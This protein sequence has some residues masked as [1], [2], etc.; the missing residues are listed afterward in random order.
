MTVPVVFDVQVFVRAVVTGNSRFYTWPSPPPTSGNPAAD[1]IGIANDAAE[2]VLWLSPHVLRNTARVLDDAFGWARDDIADYVEALVK[3]TTKAGGQVV[4]PGVTVGDCP[5]HEDNRIL[6]LSLAANAALVVSDDTDL[7]AMSPW[8]GIPVV[9]PR[10]FAGRVD[11][12]RRA[13]R[14]AGA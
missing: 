1:C 11:A 6:E 14:V 13:R 12:M 10:E 4:E 2:F 9:T 3:I 5:D 8:R 7:L